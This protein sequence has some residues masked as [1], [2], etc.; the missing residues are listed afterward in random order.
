[1][2]AQVA[3]EQGVTPDCIRQLAGQAAT[4][5]DRRAVS[6][7]NVLVYIKGK[8]LNADCPVGSKS[9]LVE[10]QDEVKKDA[11]LM[12]A[13]NHDKD[14]MAE[15]RAEYDDN[16]SDKQSAIMRVSTRSAARIVGN[17]ITAC[18]GQMDYVNDNSGAWDSAPLCVAHIRPQYSQAFLEMVYLLEDYACT[19]TTTLLSVGSKKVP[20]NKMQSATVEF[21]L[22][23]LCEIT[24]VSNL[25]MSY[26]RYDQ[27]IRAAQG[28]MVE[29][30]PVD[31][32]FIAPSKLKVAFQIQTLYNTWKLGE[33][34][35]RVMTAAEKREARQEL[36]EWEPVVRAKRSNAGGSHKRKRRPDTDDEGDADKD[37]K[38][39]D[40]DDAGYRLKKK[41]RTVV[42]NGAAIAGN[43]KDKGK[44][45]ASK[46]KYT[47]TTAN[48][49]STKRA[50]KQKSTNDN[51]DAEEAEGSSKKSRVLKKPRADKEKKPAGLKKKRKLVPGSKATI[52]EAQFVESRALAEEVR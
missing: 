17:S 42:K 38:D 12:N 18:Q 49:K 8:E 19:V 31:I 26:S 51:E 35:W 15:L 10:I 3:K 43:M 46:S 39:M 41:A 6:N 11:D 52:V 16:H 13:L 23:G 36:A 28:V 34:Y 44:K 14:R 24:K 20:T 50:P 33:A 40:D 2:V 32:K 1:M 47:D 30:W 45:G 21:I 22:Q 7:W 29:G 9:Q 37:D 48:T 5:K 27:D 25:T 4:I